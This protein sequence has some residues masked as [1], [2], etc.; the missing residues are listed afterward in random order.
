MN[1]PAARKPSTYRIERLLAALALC[2]ALIAPFGVIHLTSTQALLGFL[3]FYPLFMSGVWMAGG[4][5]FWWHWERHW[6]WGSD[7]SDK[8]KQRDVPELPGNP[9][10]AILIPCHNEAAHCADTVGAALAQHYEHIE[11]IAINDGSTDGTA[12]ILNR[13]AAQHEKLRVVHLA[14]NQGKAMA[15]R[16]GVLAARSEYLVCI[17]GD[18]LLDADAVSFLVEPMLS[19]P[20]V[21]A[22]TGNPRVRTRS[23]LI[24]RVQVGEFSSIIGLIKRTQRIYG[25][26]F[27]VSGVVA[28]FRRTAL[29]RVGYWSADMMTEDI[30]ISWKLQ[31]D[32]WTIFYEPR[33]LCWILMPE[34]L[35][36]LWRQRLRWALGGAEVF[37]KNLPTIWYWRHHRMWPLA[38]EFTLSVAWAF[39]IG[40]SILLWVVQHVVPL[41]DWLHVATLIPPGFTG[42]LLALSCL[43]QFGISVLIERRYEPKLMAALYWVIWYPLVYWMLSLAT[44]LYSF[45]TVVLRQRRRARWVSP[46][47]GI[48]A[49]SAKKA[50]KNPKGELP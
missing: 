50:A 18:A 13:L 48:A 37:L 28:A 19:K 27:T 3:F 5:L 20:H 15:L 41:P 46:D 47:R 42:M 39:A 11:V 14:T 6:Q 9:L 31:R 17:D 44:T 30:D 4:L 21:G 10:V 1:K 25:Q 7:P 2:A 36:G 8:G 49:P 45:V 24:G 16:A 23:T 22:V 29:A 12:A 35:R 32:L 38:L 26:V 34:T 33:A 40:V 43:A